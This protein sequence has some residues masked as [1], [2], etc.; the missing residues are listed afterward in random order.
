MGLLRIRGGVSPLVCWLRTAPLLPVADPLVVAV[1]MA[2][3]ALVWRTL[4][5]AVRARGLE[6]SREFVGG[7]VGVFVGQGGED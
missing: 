2:H 4:R 5:S 3:K 6:G 1:Q 7:V